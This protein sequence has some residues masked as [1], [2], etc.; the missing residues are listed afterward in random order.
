MKKVTALI[1][2]S[3]FVVPLHLFA[4]SAN[5]QTPD[6]SYTKT[7]LLADQEIASLGAEINGLI[8]KDTVTELARFHRVQ[9]SSGFSSA[10]EYIAAKAKEYGLEQVKIERLA[11]DGQKTYHTLKST[12]GWEASIAQLWEVAPRK[13]KIADLE[14]MQVALADYSQSAEVT[15]RLVDVGNG[16]AP[17]DYEGK[18]VKGKIVLAGGNV[19]LAHKLACDER[20]AVGV[21]SYQQN[22]VTG[23]SGD[24][25]DNVRWGH[26]SPYEAN[27]KFAFMISLRRARELKERLGRG[28]PITLQAK[29][30]AE[31]KPGSY[32]VV[33]AVLRGT[34]AADEEIVFSCHLC[35][36]KPGANDNASGAAAI[37]EVARA[38]STLIKR[39]DL[40][41]PRRS[42][43]FIW[44]PEINGTLAYF[45]E[46]PEI[47][48]RM[49]AAVHCDMVGG[50]FAITKSVLHVT[51]TPA[52]LPSAVNTVADIFA[53]YAIAGSLKA[54][55]AADFTDALVSSEGSK[56][57]LVADI[58][59]YEMGSDHDVYQEGSFRIPTI[60]LRDWPDV[61]IHTNND[62]PENIDATKM[63]RSA[64]IAGASGYFLA[65]A[66]AREAS[67]LA[68]EV[69]FRAMAQLPKDRARAASLEAMGG[70]IGLEESRNIIVRSLERDA[71][72]LGSTLNLAPNDR[73][74][75]SKVEGL[76]EQLSGA[77]LLLTGQITE[78]KKGNR[79]IFT[80]EPKEQVK[81]IK[82]KD[83]S[84]PKNPKEA[85]RPRAVGFDA[86]RIP[87]RRVKG[88]MNVYYYDYL[89]AHA[90]PEDLRVVERIN[91][92]PKGDI[93]LYEILN[94][95]DGRRSM[96]AIRDYLTAAY[97]VISIEEVAD[98][99][100]LLEKVGVVKIEG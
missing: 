35:H 59:P 53:E 74:L 21:V 52:S 1:L 63:K 100:R 7:P 40:E 22:Q 12:P 93:L 95:V 57:S 6:H 24:Y 92:K 99:L 4:S 69:F 71:E 16:T 77:W 67:R 84:K 85:A 14:E 79:V 62:K 25:L 82:D 56:D 5:P 96:Q 76:V 55:T 86:N 51:H 88:P 43:R 27:N 41:R 8:A 13:S 39:G 44:P 26:L 46:H 11:A 9:A 47:V 45:A 30:K 70:E 80:I 97:G 94:L 29:V 34:D 37:L 87:A 66:G 83:K 65:R 81:D 33:T 36:Q 2:L 19:A 48:R 23:W 17:A 32:D 15:A 42:I 89:A 98:Y 91:A 60:Y 49:K 18:E 10:A 73:N 90:G 28:E 78:Q 50:N 38:L 54:A 61:F 72:T 75:E 20:G 64:F 68:D 58:T 31:I 3:L